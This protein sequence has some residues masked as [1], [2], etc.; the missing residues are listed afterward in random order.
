[1][2]NKIIS[3]Y[4][5]LL[6]SLL[7]GVLGLFWLMGGKGFPFGAGDPLGTDVSMLANVQAE[8]GALVIAIAGL[9]GVI[10]ALLIIGTWGGG[11]IPRII[12]QFISWSFVI[13]IVCVVCD[14]RVLALVAYVLL[15]KFEFLDWPSINQFLCLGGGILW[16]ST[17]ITYMK[18]R[19]KEDSGR[20]EKVS[21]WLEPAAIERW[22][23]WATYTAVSLP[24]IYSLTRWAWAFNIPLGVS[25]AFLIE[26]AQDTPGIW[27]FGAAL[28]TTGAVGAVLTLGL[29]SRWG[30]IFPRWFPFVSGKRVPPTMAIIPATF[31]S[32]VVFITGLMYNRLWIKGAFPEGNI[33]TYAPELTWPIWGLALGL[34]T[35]AYHLRRKGEADIAGGLSA[36]FERSV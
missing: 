9:I 17:A 8:G 4:G 32:I 6:W 2:K 31:I 10:N 12:P 16:G 34:A 24:L 13:V 7:Y 23:K 22:G 11:N 36:G 20:A 33:A 25:K 19:R 26:E 30:E 15:L 14:Y 5:A 21:K 28:G 27:L 1:M 29:I 18:K 3:G 35:L